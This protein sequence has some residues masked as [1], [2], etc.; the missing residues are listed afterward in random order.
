MSKYTK[1]TLILFILA[2]L[3]WMMCIIAEP[4]NLELIFALAAVFCSIV[5][6]CLMAVSISQR[7]NKNLSPYRV[8]ALVD[9][10]IGLGVVLYA[11]YDILTDTGF[12]AGITGI[13]LLVTVLPMTLLLLLADFL[14]FHISQNRKK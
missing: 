9:A 3:F 14:A 10:L 13:V 1:T 4:A 5:F 6:L 2:A 7:M 12:W 8:F 11:V